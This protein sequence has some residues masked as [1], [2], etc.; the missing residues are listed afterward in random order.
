[1][2]STTASAS[3]Q[4]SGSSAGSGQAVPPMACAAGENS[5]L[6]ATARTPSRQ[7]APSRSIRTTR[8][9]HSSAT[10]ARSPAPSSAS[11]TVCASSLAGKYLPVSSSTS[12][13]PSVSNHARVASGGNARRMRATTLRE[14]P[15]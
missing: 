3:I 9:P 14:P 5:L 11:S 13:T 2:A 1:M 6:E 8:A 4:R 10:P 7:R 12:G 15:W